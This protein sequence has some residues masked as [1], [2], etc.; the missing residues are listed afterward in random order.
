MT[1]L[2]HQADSFDGSRAHQLR[3]NLTS[4][5][6]RVS[7]SAAAD[8]ALTVGAERHATVKDGGGV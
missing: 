4:R 3:S 7:R 6:N 8:D 5:I 2:A 1:R